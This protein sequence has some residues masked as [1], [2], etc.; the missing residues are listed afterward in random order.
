MR[1]GEVQVVPVQQDSEALMAQGV[2]VLVRLSTPIAK[3]P[4][5]QVKGVGTML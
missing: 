2:K 1:E 5:E 4:S 3:R